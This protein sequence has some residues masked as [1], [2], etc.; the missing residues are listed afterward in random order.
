MPS[1]LEEGLITYRTVELI[2]E[3]IKTETGKGG[4]SFYFKVNGKF[5]F[6]RGSNWIPSHALPGE[7]NY[8]KILKSD[9]VVCVLKELQTEAVARDLLNS[10]KT[11]HMTML[12]VW[13]GNVCTIHARDKRLISL[14]A[15]GIYENDFF[16]D[17]AD[18]LGILLWQDA[19][20]A[21][22]MYPA[23]DGDLARAEREV[24]HQV[25]RLQSHASVGLWAANN[26]NAVALRQ[27]WYGT[28]D[29]FE[30]YKKDYVALYVDTLMPVVAEEDPTRVIMV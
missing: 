14:I 13:G 17:A 23:A 3:P 12:R 28:K 24:R 20:F 16:Y 25:R 15:G 22:S 7:I 4:L 27:N 21:C 2:E 8:L 5:I 18:E 26:E 9:N 11:A 29:D 30:Q 6:M 10:A 19:M 1:I